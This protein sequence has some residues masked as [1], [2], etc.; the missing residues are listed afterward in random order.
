MRGFGL[1]LQ[2]AGDDR[3]R[4]RALRPQAGDAA[5]VQDGEIGLA[6]G[7]GDAGGH[8]ERGGV[9]TE[10]ERATIGLSLVIEPIPTGKDA[11]RVVDSTGLEVIGVRFLTEH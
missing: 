9:E 6:G 8:A 2:R 4:G 7:G 10:T 1:I 11:V 5:D 3:V